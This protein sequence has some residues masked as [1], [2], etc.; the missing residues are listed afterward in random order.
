MAT[1]KGLSETRPDETTGSSEVLLSTPRLRAVPLGERLRNL[2][3]AA[4]LTQSDLAGGRFSKEYLSQIERGKTRPTA[5]TILAID[6]K[7]PL[8]SR[9][10]Y[11]LG[12]SAIFASD[13]KA[14]WAAVM[15][16]DGALY[17]ASRMVN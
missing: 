15:Q 4:G 11:G 13:A 17:G 12:R 8:L 5:E 10:Q 16:N 14:R 2:R 9:W 6:R 3:A 1:D 7:D